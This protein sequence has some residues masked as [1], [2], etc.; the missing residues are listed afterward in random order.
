MGKGDLKTRKGKIFA[1]SYGKTRLR[2]RKILSEKRKAQKQ[3]ET[4]KGE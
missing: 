4:P 3:N 2:K 1:G